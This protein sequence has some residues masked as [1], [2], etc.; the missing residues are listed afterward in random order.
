MTLA[1]SLIQRFRRPQPEAE[2]AFGNRLTQM[3]R[4]HAAMLPRFH[5]FKN[6]ASRRAA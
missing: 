3:G 5:I 2:D 1:Q 6:L 4:N